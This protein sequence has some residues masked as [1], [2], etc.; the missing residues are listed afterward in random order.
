MSHRPFYL[1][2]KPQ[3][4]PEVVL[5]Q[6]GAVTDRTW[7]SQKWKGPKIDWVPY[8]KFNL[9]KFDR[10]GTTHLAIQPGHIP[11]P[12]Y[13]V[14]MT[15]GDYARHPVDTQTPMYENIILLQESLSIVPVTQ[16]R[17]GYM[18]LLA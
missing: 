13:P 7:W 12:T 11:H 6:V 4:Q 2:G 15:C 17:E 5:L 8:R 10:G 9:W 18:K 1:R 16:I 3:Q 14:Q